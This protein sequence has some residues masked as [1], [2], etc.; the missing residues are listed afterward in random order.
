MEI[1]ATPYFHRRILELLTDDEYGDLQDFLIAQPDAG[2]LIPRGRGL[3][4]LPWYA[5]KKA[6][7]KR[8][9][10]RVIYYYRVRQVLFFITVYEKNKKEDLSAEELRELVKLV[11]EI[12]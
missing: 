12:K 9:G 4:K 2:A 10:L 8:G 5:G 6:K 3:R 1:W 7:G 11:Q